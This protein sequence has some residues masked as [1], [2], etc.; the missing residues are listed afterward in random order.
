MKPIVFM[1][2]LLLAA[3]PA[4]SQDIRKDV[5]QLADKLAKHNSILGE[6]IGEGGD[7]PPEY[8]IYDTLCHLATQD[9]LLALLNHPGP[10]VRGY[11]F[12]CLKY[13]GYKDLFGAFIAHLQDTS[14]VYTMSG[15]MSGDYYTID[16]YLGV[17]DPGYATILQYSG[18]WRYKPDLSSA[19]FALLDSILIFGNVHD[20]VLKRALVASLKPEPRY[21]DALRRM[22]IEYSYPFALLKLAS[23][24]VQADTALVKDMLVDTSY[25]YPDICQQDYALKAVAKWP[26]TAFYPLLV[27]IFQA[28]FITP[29]PRDSWGLGYQFWGDLFN[30]LALYLCDETYRIFEKAATTSDTQLRDDCAK[31]LYIAIGR[32]PQELFRPLQDKIVLDAGTKEKADQAIE[33]YACT[34][35]PENGQ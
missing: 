29:S 6:A 9:E 22:I 12:Q 25:R 30:A 14:R 31:G 23:Y 35:P 2:C 17:L 4:H 5:A 18:N 15:C 11:A 20:M 19:Q 28:N 10:A 34:V 26:D 32:H 13:R 33:K 1:L 7:T 16:Y 8:K 21:Y 24:K 27:A 3:V